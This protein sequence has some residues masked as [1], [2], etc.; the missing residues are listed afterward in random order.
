MTVAS[1]PALRVGARVLLLNRDDE[2]LLIHARDPHDPGHH[3]WELPGGGQDSGESSRTLRGARSP[4][5]P[6]SSWTRLGASPGHGKAASPTA[7][8]S[9]T[10]S[11]TSTSPAPTGPH[12]RSPS[13]TPRTSAPVLSSG[14]DREPAKI[15][16]LDR[17]KDLRRRQRTILLVPVLQATSRRVTAYVQAAVAAECRNIATRRPRH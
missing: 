15:T 8:A 9:T 17:Q 16:K 14:A 2:V 12:L 3:W 7:A 6:G 1:E 5:R 10:A 13:S 4:R 11:T